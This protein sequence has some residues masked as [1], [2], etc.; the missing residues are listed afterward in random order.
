MA[1]LSNGT[2]HLDWILS[3]A[4][5]HLMYATRPNS[6]E[7]TLSSH[8]WLEMWLFVIHLCI[9]RIL[10]VTLSISCTQPFALQIIVSLLETGRLWRCIMIQP[11]L[12][13]VHAGIYHLCFLCC[14]FV[15]QR[16]ECCRIWSLSNI[17]TLFLSGDNFMIFN[18]IEHHIQFYWL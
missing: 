14:N 12:A 2:L 17:L 5:H 9:D 11:Y 13:T 3:L 7:R 1:T 18:F 15:L 16:W 6:C 10:C 8:F 4:E